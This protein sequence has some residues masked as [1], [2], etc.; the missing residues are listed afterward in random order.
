MPDPSEAQ[1]FLSNPVYYL[2]AKLYL[3]LLKSSIVYGMQA[4]REGDNL[5]AIKTPPGGRREAIKRCGVP[6]TAYP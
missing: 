6:S 5:R 2:Y 1:H 3:P 4:Y